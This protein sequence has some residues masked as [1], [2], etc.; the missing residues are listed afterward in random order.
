MLC[1]SSSIAQ[2]SSVPMIGPPNSVP[3]MGRPTDPVARMIAF[4]ASSWRPSTS[5]PRPPV[6]VAAPSISSMSFFLSSIPTP[7]V[8]ALITLPRC[9]ATPGKSTVGSPTTIP[10]SPALRTSSRRS[11][12]R[13]TALAGMQ[14]TLR[15][16]PPM[17]VRSM[18]AVFRPSWEARIA[19]T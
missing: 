12:D 10:C 17:W 8:R 14:A 6:S 18:T 16:R 3:G 5:T 9:S 2:A 11:A 4:V 19:A 1:G 13:R 7:P 15:H